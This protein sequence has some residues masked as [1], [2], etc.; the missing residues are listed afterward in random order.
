MAGPAP[1]KRNENPGIT[2]SNATNIQ[3]SAR[4]T[5][6]LTGLVDLN[7]SL[8]Q[9]HLEFEWPVPD[10]DSRALRREILARNS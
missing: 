2:A 7:H 6:V 9:L 4:N 10:C 8:R 1:K 3:V 5:R